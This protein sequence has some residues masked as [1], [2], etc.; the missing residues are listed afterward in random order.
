MYVISNFILQNSL[1]GSS[2]PEWSTK[3]LGVALK[4]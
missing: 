4:N 2:L 3:V 1:L